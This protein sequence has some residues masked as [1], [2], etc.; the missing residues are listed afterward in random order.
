MDH[1]SHLVVPRDEL[2]KALAIWITVLPAFII[3]NLVRASEPGKRQDGAEQRV[4]QARK[5]LAEAIADS[6]ARS[7]WA[8]VRRKTLGDQ[9]DEAIRASDAAAFET[10]SDPG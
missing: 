7:Q 10:R 3:R 4:S 2:T 6:F 5:A 8:V 1:D 9:L